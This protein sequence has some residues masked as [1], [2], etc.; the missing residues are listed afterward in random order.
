MREGRRYFR[1]KM[2]YWFEKRIKKKSFLFS[3]WDDRYISCGIVVSRLQNEEFDKKGKTKCILF[4]M[5]MWYFCETFK[6]IIAFLP[7]FK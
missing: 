2:K 6:L 4:S 3:M 1:F 7:V 5:Q